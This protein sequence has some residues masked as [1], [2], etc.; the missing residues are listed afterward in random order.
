[1]S[2]GRLC[3]VLGV[4]GAVPRGPWGLLGESLDLLGKSLGLL[5]ESLGCAFGVPGVSLG[6]AGACLDTRPLIFGRPR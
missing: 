2:F 5:V 1:M 3:G 4:I 6:A